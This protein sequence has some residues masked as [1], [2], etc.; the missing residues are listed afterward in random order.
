MR[1]MATWGLV[2]AVVLAGIGCS[3]DGDDGSGDPAETTEAAGADATTEATLGPC[4]FVTTEA[5]AEAITLPVELLEG[6]ETSC[7]YTLGDAATLLIAQT[8]ADGD[9][10]AAAAA[11]SCD[12]GSV[13]DVEAGD[14]A[15]AC[16]VNET[17]YATLVAGDVQITLAV[18]GSQAADATRDALAALLLQITIPD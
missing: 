6:S 17:A 9:I 5:V 7:D 18:A 10:D 13:V 4:P 8:E 12:E 1:R 11:T 2:L 14:G 16:V 3:D 15:F